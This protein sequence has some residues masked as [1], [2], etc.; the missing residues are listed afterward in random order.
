MLVLNN[1]LQNLNILQGFEQKGLKQLNKPFTTWKN[2]FHLAGKESM[3][4]ASIPFVRNLAEYSGFE[5]N[6]L[7]LTSLLH[8]KEDSQCIS[9]NNLET[10]IKAILVDKSSLTLS[11]PT[12]IVIDLIFEIADNIVGE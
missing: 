5:A 11:N 7:K 12:K 9:I 2:N 3:L 8:I 4:I 1:L 6:Y 10:I